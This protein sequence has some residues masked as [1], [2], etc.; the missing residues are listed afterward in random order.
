MDLF[1]PPETQ[2]PETNRAQVEL[3]KQGVAQN[4]SQIA[5]HE[6]VQTLGEKFKRLQALVDEQKKL[7]PHFDQFDNRLK[8]QEKTVE[9]LSSLFEEVTTTLQT[10]HEDFKEIKENLTKEILTLYQQ[11]AILQK[12]I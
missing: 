5:I 3:L 4:E 2:S 11:I 12:K 7:I 8:T 10:S 9:S 6:I 1:T